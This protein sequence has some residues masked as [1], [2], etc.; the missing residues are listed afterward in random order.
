MPACAAVYFAI[1]LGLVNV[2]DP[3]AGNP[4]LVVFGVAAA[5]AFAL[6]AALLLITD[7]IG[8]QIAGA[9]FMILVIV[10]YFVVAQQRTPAFEAWGLAL[11]AAQAAILAALVYLI[12]SPGGRCP[13]AYCAHHRDLHRHRCLVPTC[14]CDRFL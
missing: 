11:K 14:P 3:A 12:V 5:L 9:V 1:A 4:S 6:G 2:V 7:R 13:C 8:P 10:M